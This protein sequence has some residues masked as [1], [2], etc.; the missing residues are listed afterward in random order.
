MRKHFLRRKLPPREPP[1]GRYVST[2]LEAKALDST[3]DI[4]HQASGGDGMA[5]V[6]LSLRWGLVEGWEHALGTQTP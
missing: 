4:G 1:A 6:G 2:G 5:V 3:P